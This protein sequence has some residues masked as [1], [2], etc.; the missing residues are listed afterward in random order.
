VFT[1]HTQCK[2]AYKSFFKLI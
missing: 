1:Q 2:G